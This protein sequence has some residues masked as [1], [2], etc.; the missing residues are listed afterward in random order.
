MTKLPQLHH[1]NLK[2]MTDSSQQ[3]GED[4]IILIIVDVVGTVVDLM[5]NVDVDEVDS[6]EDTADT[7]REVV[8]PV[9]NVDLGAGTEVVTEEVV[10]DSVGVN[11]MEK[12]DEESTEERVGRDNIEEKVGEENT[13]ERVDEEG[14]EET[15]EEMANVAVEV[16]DVVGAN[17]EDRLERE[18]LRVVHLPL[19]LCL[20]LNLQQLH[21]RAP[22]T[23]RNDDERSVG[24]EKWA[25]LYTDLTPFPPL[26]F[27]SVDLTSLDTPFSNCYFFLNLGLKPPLYHPCCS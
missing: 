5:V 22:R 21:K 14:I 7:V 9:V 15:T 10:E 16:G 2:E 25:L 20:P 1:H 6:V 18:R 19:P 26:P 4:T 12:V 17:T 11:I 8:V 24:R 23:P 3:V 27:R 13:G